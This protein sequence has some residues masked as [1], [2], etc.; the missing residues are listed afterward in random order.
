LGAATVLEGGV[1]RA[2][3]RVRINVQLIDAATDEHLWADT[4]DRRLTAENIFAIQT[5]IAKAIADALQ[6]ALSPEE[7]ERLERQPTSNLAAY[8]AYIFGRQRLAVETISALTEAIDHFQQAV[9]LDPSFAL[10]YVGLAESYILKFFYSG[11][12]REETLA[13]AQA[14]ADKA[15]EL[16]DRLGEAHNALAGILEFSGDLEAAEAE[17][18]RALELNPNYT[19]TY[20]W[21]G[22]VLREKLDRVDEALALHMRAIEL[23]PLSADITVNIADDLSKLGR[24]EE[25][26]RWYEKAI[27]LDPGMAYAHSAIG[28]HYYL[29]RGRLDEAIVWMTRAVSFDPERADFPAQLGLTVLNLGDV[30]GAKYWIHRG[31]QL[32]SDSEISETS[33]GGFT[34]YSEQVLH[35]YRGDES[36]LDDARKAIVDFPK[37]WP[38][39]VMLLNHELKEGRTA[40]ARALYER[41]RPELLN[42]DDL[43]IN[44]KNYDSVINLA[45]V[46]IRTGERER[47]D[48]LLERSLEYVQSDSCLCRGFQVADARIYALRGDKQKALS[49]LQQA[50]DEGWRMLWWYYLKRDPALESLHD[51]PEY[52][53]MVAEIEADMATQLARVREMERNGELEPIPEVSVTTH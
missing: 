1:Q 49:A 13:K 36:S 30:E 12:L 52:Q 22:F 26:L 24:F 4:Y 9:E 39:F 3:D 35:L 21:Y 16:D 15:L 6:A 20:S 19:Q 50:V 11:Q 31:I 7:E 10:A 34:S 27:E 23:D 53:A 38:P 48:R 14:A 33:I 5:E 45:L 17:Y 32:S 40:E 44:R 41:V 2:G 28:Q 37:M 43:I 42:D 51:E 8:E 46:L 25:S 18:Q 29:F 47:A